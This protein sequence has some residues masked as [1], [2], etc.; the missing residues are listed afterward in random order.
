MQF[1]STRASDMNKTVSASHAILH[2]LA[3][4]GGLYVPI[5]FPELIMSDYL[6]QTYGAI[7]VSVLGLF[8]TEFSKDE[9]E[10]CVDASYNAQNFSHEAI[11]GIHVVGETCAYLELFY[12]QTLAFKDQALSLFPHLLLLSKKY[13]KMSKKLLILAATSG[14]TGKAAMEAVKDVAGIEIIVLYPTDGVSSMQKAQMQKQ[15]G[16]NV[17]PIGIEGNFDD[18]Q[19]AVKTVFGSEQIAKIA[20]ANNVLLTSANSINVARLL[21][22]VVY[23]VDAYARLVEQA[24]VKMGEVMNVCVPTGNFGNILAAFI[25]KKIGVPINKIICATNENKV[26]ADFIRTGCYDIRTRPFLIT[27]SPSMDI[28]VSSNLERFLAFL[29]GDNKIVAN[30]MKQLQENKC[31]T[32][33][34]AQHQLLKSHILA[35]DVTNEETITQIAKVFEAADYLIDPHTSV[36]SHALD[37]FVEEFPEEAGF[38]IVVSTAHPYKFLSCYREI[39]AINEPNDYRCADVISAITNVQVPEKI[40]ELELAE[41]RFSDVIKVAEMIPHIIKMVEKGE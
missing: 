11:T 5:D 8:F 4:D 39:F 10:A 41:T 21:P 1:R 9:L 17:F 35:Y 36:A 26:L 24:T 14:D 6:G 13:Q 38:N 12:G 30:Y 31:F 37:S 22:Q 20:A 28:L 34:Q 32:L 27:P 18:A 25:A 15:M 3:E 16:N 33:T 2:G 29:F 19:A 7:A 23:Y 40:S